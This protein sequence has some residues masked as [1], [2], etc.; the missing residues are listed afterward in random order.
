MS[1]QPFELTL[2]AIPAM[3]PVARQFTRG[4]VDYLVDAKAAGELELVITEMTESALAALPEG[5]SPGILHI[6]ASVRDDRI[7]IEVTEGGEVALVD[8]RPRDVQEYSMMLMSGCEYR[9]GRDTTQAGE[10]VRW[11]EVP[12]PKQ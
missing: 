1:E 4:L 12:C 2:P 9:W 6:R 10:L 7:R 11:V 3:A 8:R 5:V